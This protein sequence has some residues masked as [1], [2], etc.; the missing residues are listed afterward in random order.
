MIPAL[1]FLLGGGLLRAWSVKRETVWLRAADNPDAPAVLRGTWLLAEFGSALLLLGLALVG[2]KALGVTGILIGFFAIA[3]LLFALDGLPRASTHGTAQGRGGLLRVLG[4]L[5]GNSGTT[6]CSRLE[7][8]GLLTAEGDP[9]AGEERQ[10]IRRV[11]DFA[12]VQIKDVMVPLVDVTAL[13]DDFSIAQAIRVVRGQGHSRLPIFH[14]RMPNVVGM[15]HAFDLLVPGEARR[16]R[17]LMKPATFIPDMVLANDVLRRLQE[18]GTNLAVVVDEYG[19]A[20]GIVTIED[21]LEEVVGEIEDEFDPDAAAVEALADGRF[22]VPARAEVKDLNERY[23]WHL[24]EGDY[25]TIGGLLLHHFERVPACGETCQLRYVNL[26][27]SRTRERS[28]EEVE[29][30]L[31]EDPE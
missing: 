31:R 6:A 30:E 24:P 22:R 23:V 5:T 1:A 17:E 2:W 29:V 12:D 21:L 3:P 19:G 25:E 4:N 16:V 28:I 10:M 15:I 26:R 20:V 8:A 14:E 27:V 11:F 9:D 7:L 18:E 13:R